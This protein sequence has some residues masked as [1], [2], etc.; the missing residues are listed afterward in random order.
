MASTD[1]LSYCVFDMVIDLADEAATAAVEAEMARQL[2]GT[3]ANY[4][5]VSF[6]VSSSTWFEGAQSLLFL[7]ARTIGSAGLVSLRVTPFRLLQ[8][9][10]NRVKTY[11]DV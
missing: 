4:S 7:R 1:I 11:D 2:N 5:V 9:M 3:G 10:P 6:D 8:L